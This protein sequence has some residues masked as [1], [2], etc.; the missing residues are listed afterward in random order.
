MKP[1]PGRKPFRRQLVAKNKPRPCPEC[2]KFKDCKTL[3]AP[4]RRWADQDQVGGGDLLL[5]N[6]ES[7]GGNSFSLVDIAFHCDNVDQFDSA[8]SDG[9]WELILSMNVPEHVLEFIRLYYKEGLRKC[10]IARR[11]DMSDSAI[12]VRHSAAKKVVA[13]RLLRRDA[14]EV[15]R[16]VKLGHQMVED[17]FNMYFRSYSSRQVISEVLGIRRNLVYNI[18]RNLWNMYFQLDTRHGI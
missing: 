4:A 8:V 14:Y 18:V 11:L 3:C 6:S 1:G 5:E 10:E 17:I 15:L 12:N 13:D 7:G 2:D 9:A 16:F